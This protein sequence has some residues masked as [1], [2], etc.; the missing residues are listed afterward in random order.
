MISAVLTTVRRS[1]DTTDRKSSISGPDSCTKSSFITNEKGNTLLD[2]FN[3]LVKD[4]TLF[5]CLVGYFYS[6]GFYALEKALEKTEKI[7]ILIG[8]STN[9]TTYELI[10]VRAGQATSL[11][12][13]LKLAKGPP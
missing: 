4:T 1:S 5:D 3:A 7:R 13:R 10:L 9:K 8:I 2:R 12:V 11:S 6:S